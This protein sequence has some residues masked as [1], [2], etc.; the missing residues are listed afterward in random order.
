MLELAIYHAQE[1]QNLYSRLIVKNK[2][3]YSMYEPYIDYF[4]SI[5]GNDL[6]RIQYVSIDEK[7]KRLTGF[8][9]AK[10]NRTHNFIEQLIILNFDEK[11][12]FLKSKDFFLFIDD[13][14][15]VRKYRKIIFSA[16]SNN[17]ATKMYFKYL[18]EKYKIAKHSGHY[19][20][21]YLLRDGNY[22]D[23]DVFQIF[24][25]DF[26]AFL[27]KHNKIACFLDAIT[28]KWKNKNAKRL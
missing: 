12:L 2:Y 18:V 6:E 9:D 17:P 14:L 10:V 7:S 15:N 5:M 16:I 22:Y 1:L 26:N 23:L 8:G 19:T 3:K 13:L 21:H 20:N 25:D 24:P 4:L 11:G 27:K 28:E